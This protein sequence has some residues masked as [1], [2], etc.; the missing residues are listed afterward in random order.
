MLSA[1]RSRSLLGA[2]H[3]GSPTVGAI[4]EVYGQIQGKSRVRMEL[5]FPSSPSPDAGRP[6][7]DP[8]GRLDSEECPALQADRG[9]VQPCRGEEGEAQMAA[10]ALISEND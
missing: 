1:T 4:A 3:C 7:Q 8:C 6:V 5:S 9:G 10:D 2:W